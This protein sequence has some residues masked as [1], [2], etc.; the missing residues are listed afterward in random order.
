MWRGPTQQDQELQVTLQWRDALRLTRF[1]Q[2]E[3]YWLGK[4][5]VS[6]SLYIWHESQ[7]L[8][9]STGSPGVPLASAV[10]EPDSATFFSWVPVL[11]GRA[12]LSYLLQLS[13]CAMWEEPDSV[14]Y[15]E[16]VGLY[17][18]SRESSANPC[19]ACGGHSV[20]LVLST[21]VVYISWRVWLSAVHWVLVAAAQQILAELVE[22]ES[23]SGSENP[24][25]AG[26]E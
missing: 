3:N 24:C 6:P 13:P 22:G 4:W 7:T 10:G 23:R 21:P 2:I 9:F 18:S 14:I 25:W 19:W 5:A 1:T 16:S 15:T 17:I 11:C 8:S 12:R 20:T 26:G